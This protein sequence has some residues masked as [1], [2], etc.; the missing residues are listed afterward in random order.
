LVLRDATGMIFMLYRQSI[1]FARFL[2][3]VGAAD[4][5]IGQ[6]VD[7]EGWFRRGLKPYVEMSRLTGE[8]GSVHRTYSRWIQ[9]ALAMGAVVVGGFW[10]M[11]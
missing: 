7:V 6:T 11:G 8:D 5:L 2:F 4:T 3:A 9:C 1:P 10:L